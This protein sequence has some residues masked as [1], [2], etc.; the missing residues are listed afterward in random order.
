MA[1]GQSGAYGYQAN[2]SWLKGQLE[3]STT[4]RR[5]KLRYIPRHASENRIDDFGGSVILADNQQLQS[6]S[7]GQFVQVEG[8]LL[9]NDPGIVDFAPTYQIA[10]IYPQ[11]H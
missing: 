9:G 3:Y 6:F 1:M 8:R 4:A 2:Y 10:R 7:P 5:W 11:N